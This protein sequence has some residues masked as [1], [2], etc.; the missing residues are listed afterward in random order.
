MAFIDY[1]NELTG[2]IPKFS[3]ELARNVV[4]RAWRDIQE[5]RPW[6]FLCYEDI[7]QA[8]K[9]V[10]A[11]TVTL[12]QYS[13]IVTPDAT[14]KAAWAA[15]A[16]PLISQRQFRLASGPIYNIVGYNPVSGAITLDRQYQEAGGA[17]KQYIMY[18][19][20]YPAP[21]KDFLR[22]VTVLD[23]TNGYWLKLHWTKKELDRL[24][25][26]RG[27]IGQPTRIASYK[28]DNNPA[29]ATYQYPL[30]ELWA[31]PNTQ[32]SYTCLYQRRGLQ[33]VNPGDSLP[34]AIQDD[35][36]LWRAKMEA[37]EWA[38]ANK[39]RFPEL[40]GSDWRFL[41]DTAA[42]HFKE[43]L[44]KAQKQDEET[45]LQ[46]FLCPPDSDAFLGPVDSAY[47]QSHDTDSL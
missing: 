31:H 17:G 11:G 15:L 46:Q 9:L 45:F 13:A 24:D 32:V 34:P 28:G 25:P 4:N 21:V 19:C 6:S 8:P 16:N 2:W 3:I 36:L 26:Q 29:S 43:E 5:S 44:F 18:R 35:V 42:S 7:L 33:F 41:H 1:T 40:R 27:N 20:Y 22:W 39:G 10:N 47:M 37:Y 14:A 12:A 30:Y 38:E 23:P